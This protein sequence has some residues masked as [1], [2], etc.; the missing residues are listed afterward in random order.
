MRRK[1]FLPALLLAALLCV[2]LL[3][4][5]CGGGGGGK[6]GGDL[7]GGAFGVNSLL[8]SAQTLMEQMAKRSDLVVL[9]CRKA[10]NDD[11]SFTGIPG[12]KYWPYDKEH[13]KGSHR[14][15]MFTF[16]DPYCT[17]A[18][19]VNVDAALSALG[20]TVNTPICLYD[21]DIDNPQGKVFFQLER[22]GCTN[23]HILNG[24]FT[25]WKKV[26]GAVSAIA[27]PPPVPSAYAAVIDTT[28]ET[29]LAG[30]KAIWD[31]VD[32]GL[33][34][35]DLYTLTDYRE[36]PLWHGHKICPDAWYHGHIPHTGLLNWKNQFDSTTGLFKTKDQITKLSLAA[37]LKRGKINVII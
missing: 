27:T 7:G 19:Q 22:R 31:Q 21:K 2:G 36:E 8:W 14:F 33:P 23:V 4:G 9:D 16:G 12:A 11:G 29:D 30:F 37:G 1:L 3:A 20:I 10:V 24:G 5:G 26:N 6:K 18:H 32:Q 13:I 34:N 17:P 15:D 25:N 35:A 28:C